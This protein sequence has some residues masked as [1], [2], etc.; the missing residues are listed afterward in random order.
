MPSCIRAPPEDGTTISAA[1]RSTASARRR[2]NRFADRDPHRSAHEGE[3]ERRHDCGKAADL[4]VRHRDC[5]AAA[6]L[7]GLRLP[8]PVGIALAIAE[9]QRIERGFRLLDPLE[10]AVIEQHL[11]P[12]RPADPEVMPAIAAHLEIGRELAMEQHLLATRALAPQIVG[13]VL[14][15]QRT[16]L[17]QHVIG[18][19]VHALAYGQFWA[20]W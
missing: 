7:R 15:R 10:S 19:P 20:E 9:A 18:Q 1:P 6:A 13:H 11:E 12:R 4:A 17:R 2:D 16:D 14:A 5:V 3:I 8:E